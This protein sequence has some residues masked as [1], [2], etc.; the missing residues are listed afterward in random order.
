MGF[1]A[2]NLGGTTSALYTN[3]LADQLMT[4]SLM[5]FDSDK[6]VVNANIDALGGNFAATYAY[7][8]WSSYDGDMNEFDL[9]YTTNFGALDLAELMQILIQMWKY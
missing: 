3:T 2:F 7:T 9:S 8:D 4:S 5:N 1:G 6:Y